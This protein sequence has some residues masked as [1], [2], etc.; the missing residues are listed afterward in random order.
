M[1]HVIVW[2]IALSFG[3]VVTY[4]LAGLDHAISTLVAGAIVIFSFLFTRFFKVAGRHGVSKMGT[5]WLAQELRRMTLRVLLTLV[6]AGFAFK[7]TYPDWGVAF[8]LSVAIYYQVGL[9]LHLRDIRKPVP[10]EEKTTV[11]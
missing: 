3:F 7:L 10:S 6:L 4:A 9:L 11:V 1:S 8:W 5:A 2:L